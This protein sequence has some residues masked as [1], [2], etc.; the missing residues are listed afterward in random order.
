MTATAHQ[1]TVMTKATI[2][3]GKTH[4]AVE[5][6]Q[7]DL[8]VGE[9]VEQPADPAGVR[10]GGAVARPGDGAAEDLGEQVTLEVG[11][12]AG[13]E[14]GGREDE[15]ADTEERDRPTPTEK[16]VTKRTKPITAVGKPISA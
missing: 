2:A 11:E 3:K 9:R 5:Q 14:Q 13:D 15:Q 8:A 6:V 7:P 1:I 16:P 10:R 4:D 12:A